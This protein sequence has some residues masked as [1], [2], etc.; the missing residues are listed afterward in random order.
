VPSTSEKG[1][2]QY[3]TAGVETGETSRWWSTAP[4][5][6]SL[7]CTVGSQA[8]APSL[9][10]IGFQPSLGRGLPGPTVDTVCRIIDQS[11]QWLGIGYL[12]RLQRE[13]PNHRQQSVCGGIEGA[14]DG[15][16]I[17]PLA[18]CRYMPGRMSSWLI[19]LPPGHARLERVSLLASPVR[20]SRK[21]TGTAVLSRMIVHQGCDKAV[22]YSLP[23]R[24][25]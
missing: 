3:Y 11:V 20:R 14:S 13:S 2:A 15:T 8:S 25:R 7:S 22:Q 16:V 23:R 18:V 4:S 9:I 17:A 12:G 21:L 24:N 6:R 1:P 19:P 10:W 5:M